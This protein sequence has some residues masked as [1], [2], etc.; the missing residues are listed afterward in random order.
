MNAT[1]VEGSAPPVIPQKLPNV[2]DIYALSPMQQ[3]M[4]FHSLHDPEAGMYCWQQGCQIDGGLDAQAFRRAWEEVVRRHAVLRTGFLWEGLSE[5]MQVVR[6][7]ADLLWREEDWR[8]LGEIDRNE[9]WR[10]FLQEDMKRGFDLKKPPLLRLAL[11][12]ISD[13]SY[14]FSWSTHHIVLD[15]WCRQIVTE[16]TFT[17]YEA[18]R[19]GRVPQLRPPSLYRD[20]IAWLQTQN[21][22]K[23]EDF[24]G[25]ELKGFSAP[26]RLGIERERKELREGEDENGV[27]LEHLG[28]E[29]S[30]KLEEIARGN[31]V[32]LNTVMQGAWAVLLSRYSGEQDVV[33]GAIVSGRSGGSAAFEKTVGVFINALPVRVQMNREKTVALYLKH[34]QAKQ[35]EARQYEY[36][37]LLKVQQW[38]EVPRGTQLFQNIVVFENYPSDSA[39]RKA[40]GGGAHVTLLPDAEINSYPLTL[41][42]SMGATLS[43]SLSYHSRW[44]DGKCM[45]RLLGHLRAVLEGMAA[46]P[47][48]R[49]GGLSLLAESDREQVLAEWN[50][51][52][53]AYPQKCVQQLFQK[54]ARRTPEALAVDYKGRRLT[55]AELD[56]RANQL[57]RYLRKLGV[58]AESRVGLCVER[59][60]E[61]VIGLL[62][63]LKAGGAYVPLDPGYPSERLQFMVKD[64]GLQVLLSRGAFA[65]QCRAFGATVARLDAD[66]QE[67]AQESTDDFDAG[68]VPQNLA[69]VIYTSGSTGQPKGVLGLHC[70]VVNRLAWMQERFPFEDG[71]VCCQ[72]TSIS[73]VDSI[74]ELLAPLLGGIKVVVISEKDAKDPRELIKVLAEQNVSRIVLVPSLLEAIL[75]SEDI[76]KTS[77]P[78]L[79]FW[80][81]SGEALPA[82]MVSKFKRIMGDRSLLNLYGSSEVS[83]DATWMEMRNNSNKGLIGKPIANVQ[84]YVLDE[85]LEP[86]SVGVQGGLYVGGVGLARGYWNRADLTAERFV[87]N[88]FSQ[89]RGE[90]LYQTGDL[91]KRLEDGNLEFL[92][93]QD[94]QIKLR[95]YRI[96]L[97]EIESVLLGYAGVKQAA[98]ILR[99]DKAGD[100]RLIGY[101]AFENEHHQPQREHL[102]DYL[103]TKLPEHMVPAAVVELR[104]LPLTPSG[105][106]DRKA[107]PQPEFA[108]SGIDWLPSDEVELQLTSIWE[109]VLQVSPVGRRQTFFELGGHSLLA[110]KLIRKI[111]EQFGQALQL[112]V[113]LENPT[114]ERLSSIL[115]RGDR[116]LL[117]SNLVPIQRHGAK[118]PVFFVHPGGG[119]ALGYM[120]LS[121]LLGKDQ[122]FYAFQALDDE[123]NR[124]ESTLSVEERAAQYVKCLREVQPQGPYLLG[125][126]SFGGYVA[127]EMAQQLWRNQEMAGL[128]LLD[129]TA[130]P[131]ATLPYEGDYADLLLRFAQESTKMNFSLPSV[132][133]CS[134][135]KRVQHVIDQLIKAGL[136]PAEVEF[137]QVLNFLIGLRGRLLSMIHYK[138]RFYPGMITLV[139]ASNSTPRMDGTGI[140][141]EDPT[142]GFAKLSSQRVQVC[143]VQGIHDEMTMPP[144]VA[145]V[146]TVMQEWLE[147]MEKWAAKA[148]NSTKSMENGTSSIPHAASL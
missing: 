58:G 104:E 130:Q 124:R 83:A 79:K 134:E 28:R 51:T 57:G 100:Q 32:T 13:D 119:N 21:Q 29:L 143:F 88:P 64:S 101:V 127:Y 138:P 76:S 131:P 103:R 112:S 37:S 72:K 36:S 45:K 30:G 63:I 114:I 96:E 23:A 97:G 52:D 123:E 108:A 4:L 132:E 111:K 40:V 3:G 74:A 62:G 60:L 78:N 9:R 14:Y 17:I 70:G 120:H 18:Y 5:P 148:F 125:G 35:A 82:A 53:G 80:V 141:P 71:E 11:I 116:P 19:A 20:Y 86:V 22:E 44:F 98:V 126:Y 133:G 48:E 47:Q 135:E 136:L 144:Q 68:I 121:R 91:A 26:T 42:V 145:G 142:L 94:Q 54:Q 7:K 39:T 102:Q 8:D 107:L 109:S 2:E 92:G 24:W 34:L 59:S 31:Q 16:E 99:E 12:R 46:G 38:S 66:W 65:E 128:V 41:T 61:M 140:D 146:A 27:V 90:R 1:R 95:G 105:K 110:V 73:F 15:G 137:A 75:E 69:Y 84:A 55:Y 25:K 117:K 122:P 118:R 89:I 6:K 10:E 106:V 67:I 87:P 81:S 93:R 85:E 129:I 49:V 50:Q 77:L 139:R 113:L 33:F 43:Y 56:R 147:A 115:R